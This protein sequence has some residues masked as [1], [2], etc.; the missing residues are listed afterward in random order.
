M[1]VHRQAAEPWTVTLI[2]TGEDTMTGGRL[3]RVAPYLDDTFCLTYGDGIADVNI[4]GL[5]ATHKAA[6]RRATVTSVKPSGRFGAMEITG[7]RVTN[8]IEKPQGDGRSINGGFFVCE[9]NV[10]DLIDGDATFWERE[11]LESLAR[12][13]QLTVYQHEGFW[14]AMDTLRDRN[15]LE[16]L[17]ASKSP[18]WQIWT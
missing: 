11:P 1:E 9:P 4:T 10:L 2:D 15:A 3:K 12:D 16:K 13:E 18:P 5:I 14:A 7:D 6:G 17:W 8:F